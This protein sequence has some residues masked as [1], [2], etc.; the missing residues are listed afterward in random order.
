MAN[1]NEMF[2]DILSKKESFFI[3]SD[4]EA[5]T[6][7]IPNVRGEFY[8]HLKNATQKEVEFSRDGSKYKAI[9]YNYDFEVARDNKVQSYTYKSYKDNTE[10]VASGEDY[11]G[12]TY[13]GNGV[14]RF[15][16]PAEGD[17]FESNATG[18]Q[19][20]L[21]FCETLKV[22]IPKKVVEMNGESVEVQALPSLDSGEINGKPA[23]AVIDK[24]KPYE[25]KGKER[26]PYVV[27]FIKLWK[28]GEMS[29]DVPF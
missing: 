11:V 5:K 29:N 6:P 20:Y 24:G 17:K 19:S 9:V 18:N 4:S 12:R 7:V 2:D 25:W 27:K 14:F 8:G 13:K 22:E 23:I 10:Q 3:P 1:S 28:D 21:R 16:E 15:L 26:T